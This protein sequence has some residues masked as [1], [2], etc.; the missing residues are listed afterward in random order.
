MMGLNLNTSNRAKNARCK[1]MLPLILVSWIGAHFIVLFGVKITFFEAILKPE[2]YKA[3]AGSFPI[4]L[5]LA[6]YVDY[7]SKKLDR[8]WCWITQSLHRALAQAVFGV[9][10][11]GLVAFILAFVY[12]Q[13][14]GIHILDTLYLRIDFP[15]VLLL[16]FA[17][18]VL[19]ASRYFYSRLQSVLRPAG[20]AHPTSV[21]RSLSPQTVE[22]DLVP[23][24]QTLSAQ[25][26]GK[27]FAVPVS[28][29]C[30]ITLE[31]EQRYVS[32]FSGDKFLVALSMEQIEKQLDARQFF[33]ASR[34]VIINIGACAHYSTIEY[35]KLEVFTAPP[36][37][38]KLTIS[39]GRARAFKDWMNR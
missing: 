19:L 25:K 23:M 28:D 9:L 14:R 26:A 35:N 15:M 16:I 31:E 18:N 30:Y 1:K 39:Q 20:H 11:T 7:V 33:R 12:F 5:L 36:M 37:P 32:T 27:V 22:E 29:I 38:E 34:Q 13:M 24:K 2:Y 4:A 21:T 3:M 17:L 6:W 8:R 10:L